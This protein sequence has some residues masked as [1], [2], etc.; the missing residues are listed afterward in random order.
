LPGNQ[1]LILSKNPASLPESIMNSGPCPFINRVHVPGLISHEV[2]FSNKAICFLRSIGP[3][4][5]HFDE[6][7]QN[8]AK[9][10]ST[11]LDLN[12]KKFKLCQC[13]QLKTGGN[14]AGKGRAS[15]DLHAPERLNGF[16]G[17]MVL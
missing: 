15:I 14:S 8:A 13:W 16:S 6:F 9:L 4:F 3:V 11:H 7:L 1:N 2:L 12:Q 10:Y 5:K 17:A